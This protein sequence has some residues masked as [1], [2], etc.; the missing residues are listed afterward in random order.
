MLGLDLRPHTLNTDSNTEPLLSN[1]SQYSFN[2]LK[3]KAPDLGRHETFNEKTLS[4]EEDE[5]YYCCGLEK[6]RVLTDICSTS[7]GDSTLPQCPGD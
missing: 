3:M 6:L 2:L 7:Y 5:G 4:T 1:P